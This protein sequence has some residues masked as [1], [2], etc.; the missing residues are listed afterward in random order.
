MTNEE[1]RLLLDAYMAATVAQD[2]DAIEGFLDADFTLW[3]VPS[4]ADHGIE[5]PLSGRQRYLDFVAEL[6]DR[7]TMWTPRD[8]RI[9]DVFYG[10]DAAAIRVRLIGEYA[11]GFQYDNEYVFTFRFRSGK[12][13]EKREFVDTAYIATL[14]GRAAEYES[15]G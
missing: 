4:A 3:M 2:F 13:L 7:P 6:N 11:S 8:F 12:V 9:E 5:N 1:I 10:N 14:N 15:R